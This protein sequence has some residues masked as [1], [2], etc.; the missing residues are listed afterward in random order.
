MAKIWLFLYIPLEAESETQERARKV[1][2]DDSE[3]EKEEGESWEDY[4]YRRTREYN[5]RTREDPYNVPLWL[6]FAQFQVLFDDL[7]CTCCQNF[8][9]SFSFIP[10]LAP[11]SILQDQFSRKVSKAITVFI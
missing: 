11:F 6:E 4:L 5:E 7:C 10:S 2:L 8:P 1:P 9:F 3:E